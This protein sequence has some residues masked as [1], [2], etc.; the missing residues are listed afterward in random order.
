MNAR[1]MYERIEYL[2]L[3]HKAFLKGRPASD[4]VP[5][6]VQLCCAAQTCCIAAKFDADHDGKVDGVHT[7]LDFAQVKCRRDG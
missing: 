4:I 6:V 5:V 3:D 2:G 7:P 1:V